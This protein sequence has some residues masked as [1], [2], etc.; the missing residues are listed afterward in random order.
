[1]LK[2]KLG[3]AILAVMLMTAMVLSG[4]TKDKSPKDALQASISKSSDIKSYNF[5][6][7]MKF[8]EFTSRTTR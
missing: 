2:R 4:C 1:M 6:G 7:S 3:F 5:K 8:E